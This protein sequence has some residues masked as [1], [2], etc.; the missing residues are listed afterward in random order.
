MEGGDERVGTRQDIEGPQ[1]TTR[2]FVTAV[3]DLDGWGVDDEGVLRS[4]RLS[5]AALHAIAGHLAET[6]Q[7]GV[8]VDVEGGWDN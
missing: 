6:G 8:Y 4:V 5:P 3:D 7:G 2:V 1:A